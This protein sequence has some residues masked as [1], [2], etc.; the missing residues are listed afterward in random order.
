MRQI[1][2]KAVTLTELLIIVI[3]I[4]I[5]AGMAV[6]RFTKS[7]EDA[8]EREARTTLELI[9][10]AQKIYRLDKDVFAGGFGWLTSYM[11]DP[12]TTADYYAY[13]IPLADATAT[14]FTAQAQRKNATKTFQIDETGAIIK[15][16]D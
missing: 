2:C 13:R 10:N 3:I 5:L 7:M 4:A 8:R 1:C 12:N 16:L 14:T 11:E 6:P 9:Y 15:L